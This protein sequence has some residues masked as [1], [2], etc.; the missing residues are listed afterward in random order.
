[1]SLDSTS[2]EGVGKAHST[3]W[4]CCTNIKHPETMVLVGNVN[5]FGTI[6][7][8]FNISGIG[9]IVVNH[10]NALEYYKQGPFLKHILLKAACSRLPLVQKFTEWRVHFGWIYFTYHLQYSHLTLNT[11]PQGCSS[12]YPHSNPWPHPRFPLPISDASSLNFKI[13][14]ATRQR[15]TH[16]GHIWILQNLPATWRTIPLS[17]WLITF[18]NHLIFIIQLHMG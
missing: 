17:N 16:T 6:W 11:P 10:N 13:S 9:L 1:M 14:K 5:I 3:P 15:V 7:V 8:V 2:I 4:S 12:N 18:N